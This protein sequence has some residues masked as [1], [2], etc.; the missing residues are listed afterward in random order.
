MRVAKELKL[1]ESEKSDWKTALV[2]T[3]KLKAFDPLDP[4][5]YDIALFG[6]G[7]SGHPH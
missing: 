3:E 6:W 2:L 1:I 5:K 7:V 4:V